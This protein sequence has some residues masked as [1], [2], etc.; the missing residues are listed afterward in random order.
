MKTKLLT[1]GGILASS[2]LLA[3]GNL[4]QNGSFESVSKKIKEAGGITYA[5]PWTSATDNKADLFSTRSKG[6][7]WGTPKNKYGDADPKDGSSYA[8]VVIYSYKDAE[9]RT[10]LQTKLTETLEEEKVYCVKMGVMLGMLSKYASNNI[11]IYVSDKPV[12][13]EALEA[14]A[15]TPQIMHSQNKV[16]DEQFEWTDICQ[17][18]IAK[19]GEKYITIGNFGATAETVAEKV[20]KPKGITGTQAR[21]AYYYIDD[22]SVMNMAG[23]ESCDCEVDASGSALQVK[24]SKDVSTDMEVDVT[25]DIEMSRIYFKEMSSELSE[26]A[27]ITVTKVAELLKAH[28]SYKVQI[29]GHTDPVEEVKVTGDV[30]LNRATVVRDKLV[31]LGA[32]DK[33]LQIQGVQDF[34]PATSDASTAGQA[35]NRRVVFKV[36]GK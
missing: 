35:Q 11:G 6:E 12:D 18:Y 23:V 26:E 32:Y 29:T 3:Q 31:E 28:P 34:D 30:S 8:G 7:D 20:K 9:P 33:K 22:V 27:L 10:Y 21:T 25:E 13:A 1:L 5:Y 2:L 15:I 19:G 4:V 36:V 14:N 24:Y 17:T 16:F